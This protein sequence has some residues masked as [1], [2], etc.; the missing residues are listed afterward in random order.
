MVLFSCVSVIYSRVGSDF[1]SIEPAAVACM[2]YLNYLY[3]MASK[4]TSQSI[5]IAISHWYYIC[6]T[7]F[8]LLLSLCSNKERGDLYKKILLYVYGRR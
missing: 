2:M 6:N 3:C 8:L 5:D 4:K 1:R 7:F